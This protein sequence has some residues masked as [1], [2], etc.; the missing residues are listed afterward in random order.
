MLQLDEHFRNRAY[1]GGI[2]I[3]IPSSWNDNA[4]YEPVGLENLER[5][6]VLIEKSDGNDSPFALKVNPDCGSEGLYI[7]LTDQY[8]LNSTV[9]SPYG[10]ID[11]VRTR[12]NH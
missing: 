10:P 11:K 7:R 9:A 8:L 5:S 12:D 4:E 6:N 1:F 2:T 3:L